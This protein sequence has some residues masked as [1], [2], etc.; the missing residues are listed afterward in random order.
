MPPCY[1]LDGGTVPLC[2]LLG[3][4]EGATLLPADWEGRCHLA[5][6]WVEESATLI[7]AG[8]EGR[9]HLVT[10]WVGGTF[11]TVGSYRTFPHS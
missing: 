10:C 7:P 5:T 1:L 4:R 8:W 9:C 2:Y 6:C 3:G 11:P